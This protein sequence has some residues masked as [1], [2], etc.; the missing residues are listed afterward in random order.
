MALSIPI[1]STFDNKGIKQATQSF[2]GLQDAG[3]RA[4]NA[5][6]KSILPA[7]IAV[8]A[9]GAVLVSAVKGA[10]EDQVAQKE[11]A[12]VLQK[13][14]NAT[15]AQIASVEDWITVQGKLLGITD[16]EL[17]PAFAGLLRATG[18]VTKAQKLSAIAFDI[19][20]SKGLPLKT[21]TNA[22]EKAYG[23]NYIALTKL[24]PEYR[25]MIKNGAS[26][27]EVMK[28]LAEATGG[29]AAGAAD[30]FQGKLK[31]LNVQF[32][33]FKETIGNA[34][35]PVLTVLLDFIMEKI[36]PAFETLGRF[37]GDF[38]KSVKKDGVTSAVTDAFKNIVTYIKE[39]ALPAI[40]KAL[41]EMGQAFIDWIKPR[42]KPMLTALGGL[43]SAG[44]RWLVDKGLPK[45][46]DKMEELGDALVDWIK[47][48]I[49]P[50]LEE[51]GKLL[52]AIAEWIVTDGLPK[53]VVLWA[54]WNAAVLGWMVELAPEIAKGL[55]KMAVELSQILPKVIAKLVPVF[56]DFGVA[57]GKAVANAIIG[58]VN[59]AF[60][61]IA[62]M[63]KGPL[64]G[65]L[66]DIDVPNIPE[67]AKG[68]I[69]TRPTLALIGEGR[70]PEAVIPLNRM[71]EFG[72][73]GGMNITVQTGVGDPV[74]IGKA[75]SDVLNAYNR[76]TGNA[77]A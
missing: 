37:I 20:A 1:I 45:M 6:K 16:D 22:L 43:I 67:L 24:A 75:V 10:M 11:L 14:T 26:F 76:R 53:L 55:F 4:G 48:K 50:M 47:P 60:D 13:T 17:R 71:G 30:T 62:N 2:Q 27:E 40:G 9:L 33:E 52:S 58:Q 25:D 68:G 59:D 5:L 61:R 64:G 19:A 38:G 3:K 42:Y 18:S 39:D 21:V 28:K 35:I 41:G 77:A 36:V 69:V 73:G 66:P 46:I 23:G 74:A 57:M 34:L 63:A 56:A 54:Q 51:L 44:A 29:A 31:I 8:A 12:R 15:D 49:A 7:T 65:I 32:D 70:G 72:M